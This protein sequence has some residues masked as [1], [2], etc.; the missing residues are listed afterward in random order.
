MKRVPVATLCV[1]LLGSC[2]WS[3]G[4]QTFEDCILNHMRGVTDKRAA[5]EIRWACEEKFAGRDAQKKKS[6]DLKATEL[7]ALTGQAGLKDTGYFSGTLYNGN[8]KITVTQLRVQVMPKA[9]S[10]P[11]S[12]PEGSV[13]D[14]PWTEFAKPWE[15]DL[16][17]GRI[18]Q[19]D[20]TIRP[21]SAGT[22]IFEIILEPDLFTAY[23]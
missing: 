6:R 9:A 13:P 23:D 2:D 18:Y 11:P 8:D 22:F 20:V 3:T 7:E 5:V 21:L 1:A 12:L 16:V 4:P 14:G 10:A 17:A 15:K 19:T